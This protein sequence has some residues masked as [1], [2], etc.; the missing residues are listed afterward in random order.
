[1]RYIILAAAILFSSIAAAHEMTPTY[2]NIKLTAYDGVRVVE[3]MI[4]NRRDDVSYYQFEAYDENWTPIAYASYDRV[5]KL[6]FG[7]AKGVT[8][9]FK[10]KDAK[11]LTYICSRSL[12]E[13]G[14][15]SLI[16]SKVKGIRT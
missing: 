4:V 3:M 8:L 12:V 15:S 13:T 5:I 11:R 7:A 16:C 1:M 2:F 6:D 9:Y 14:V 10:S